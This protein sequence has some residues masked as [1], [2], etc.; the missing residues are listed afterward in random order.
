MYK[1]LSL[2]IVLYLFVSFCI[3]YEVLPVQISGKI[4]GQKNIRLWTYYQDIF[5]ECREGEHVG[6]NS[7]YVYLFF[8]ESIRINRDIYKF[9]YSDF[10]SFDYTGNDTLYIFFN[11]VEYNI[12]VSSQANVD[13]REQYHLKFS[14]PFKNRSEAFFYFLPPFLLALPISVYFAIRVYRSRS[15]EVR[16]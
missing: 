2:C 3:S 6:F 8:N 5:L 11:N 9:N 7:V 4:P 13:F 14:F 16:S 10:Y 1:K 12:I 15:V